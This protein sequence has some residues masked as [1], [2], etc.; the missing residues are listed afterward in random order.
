MQSEL[1]NGY[2]GTFLFEIANIGDVIDLNRFMSHFKD[3][4]S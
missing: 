4:C 2:A 1:S 3:L